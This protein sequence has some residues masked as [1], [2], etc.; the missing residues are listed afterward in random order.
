MALMGQQLRNAVM[1]AKNRE[2]LEGQKCITKLN[3]ELIK[4]VSKSVG[5]TAEESEKL[6]YAGFYDIEAAK[7]AVQAVIT[8]CDSI[9][10]T[11]EEML[12]KMRADMTQLNS[13]ME[14]LEPYVDSVKVKTLE[15][16][17]N[18]SFGNAKKLNF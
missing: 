18:P 16:N 13:L 3:D 2:V 12:P 4:E 17:A 11:A 5:L 7:E 9:K 8:S 15:E 14:E 6:I 1:N 10:K